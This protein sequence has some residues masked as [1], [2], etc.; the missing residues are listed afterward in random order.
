MSVMPTATVAGIR[1]TR[2]LSGD[3]LPTVRGTR[4]VSS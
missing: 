3:K 1:L 4:W 2:K